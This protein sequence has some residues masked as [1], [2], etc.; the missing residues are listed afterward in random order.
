LRVNGQPF[1][2]LEEQTSQIGELTRPQEFDPP[3]YLG[4]GCKVDVFGEVAATAT[5]TS[6]LGASFHL[7][8]KVPGT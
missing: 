7:L 2:P 1:Y 8:L 5:V 4:R 3:I 6:K